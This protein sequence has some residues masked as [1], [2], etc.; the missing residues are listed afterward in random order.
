MNSN[1]KADGK[2]LIEFV[3]FILK[4]YAILISF[5]DNQLLQLHCV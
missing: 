3:F 1:V 2:S 4:V 5:I